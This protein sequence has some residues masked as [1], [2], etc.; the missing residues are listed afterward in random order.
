MSGF[1]NVRAQEHQHTE[2][3]WL[4]E[5][6]AAGDVK[7]GD[8]EHELDSDENQKLK[9]RLQSWYFEEREKQAVNR[10]Q[11]AIDHDYYDSIQWSEEDAADVESR[12]QAAIVFNEVA[13]MV[14]WIIG[15]ERRAR[16]DWDV[17][18]RGPSDVAT[19]DV[20]KKV[21]KYVSDINDVPFNRSRAFDDAVKAGLGWLEDGARNDPTK[22]I[23]FSGYEDWR[24]VLHDSAGLDLDLGDGRYL[25]RWRWV[26]LDVAVAMFPTRERQLRKAAVNHQ[27]YGNDDDD[28]YYLGQHFQ[29]SDRNGQVM[30][31]RTY[32]GDPFMVGTRRQRV[33]LIEAWYRVPTKCRMCTGEVFDGQVYEE[34]HP[35]MV[36]AANDGVISLVDAVVMRMHY[37]VMTAGDLMCKGVTPYRHQRFPLTPIWCYRRGR[38]RMPY[39]AIRRVRDIQD[40]MNKRMSKAQFI[41]STNQLWGEEG[42]VEDWDEAREEADRP[43]GVIIRRKGKE[44]EA[45]R[46][47][48]MG[49]AHLK[50][51]EIESVK[52]QHSGGVNN[53]NLGRQTNAESGE[54][55]KARQLQGSVSNTQVFDNERMA[56][57]WQGE[58]QLSN[59]EQF[60]TEPKVIR[61]SEAKGPIQWL[62]INQPEAQP[63]GSVRWLN[64]ITASQ[65]DFVV[66]E[67]DYHGTLR[68]AMFESMMQMVA[69][70]PPELALR[71]LR[72]A[73][74]F[75]DFPNKDEIVAEIRRMTGEP[76]P[77][78]KMTPEEMQQMEQQRA[79]QEAMFAQQQA[80]IAAVVAEQ[81]AK[82]KKLNAEAEKII[83]EVDLM[84]RGADGDAANQITDAVRKVQ[85]ESAAQ[86]ERVTRQMVHLQGE[87]SQSQIQLANRT[88]EI[89]KEAD[90]KIEVARIEADAKKH[91]EDVKNHAAEASAPLLKQLEDVGRTVADLAKQLAEETRDREKAEK[92]LA[93]TIEQGEKDRK[94]EAD[95]KAKETAAAKPGAE[96]APAAG[97]LHVHIPGQPSGDKTV[98]LTGPGGQE[99]KGTLKTGAAAGGSS[100]GK[101]ALVQAAADIAA[102]VKAMEAERGKSKTVT[103]KGPDGKELTGTVHPSQKEKG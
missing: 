32:T 45:R 79:A 88:H 41:F 102:S 66:S 18:P 80:Q 63:D 26:D 57:K 33:K 71:L 21:L 94:A 23:L 78:R 54:A 5:E 34:K 56:V 31:R 20:K 27:L 37:A 4:D 24:N 64:D 19:A 12:G 87:L 58:K 90:T 89:D 7:D 103:V 29:A 76:D 14:D 95:R 68:Q 83:A 65:A 25:Y 81:Q 48:E 99:I 40:D 42:A 6:M 30:S 98:T 10:Y 72:L 52:I 50:L 35:G 70:M 91:A 8:K 55:I 3:L 73:Y 36:Q 77:S 39:G 69:K 53:D 46:D 44:L 9:S 28:F 62:H 15:T 100:P 85:A 60:Y 84:L 93:K 51:M 16:V 38:D 82:A 101:D 11:M 49:E 13:V 86:V 59:V 1:T 43:D 97:E 67:Q 2:E 61:I 96:A 92:E 47:S 75:S 74:E 22:D 17:L